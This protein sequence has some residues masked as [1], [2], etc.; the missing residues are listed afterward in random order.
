MQ[1]MIG[2]VMPDSPAAKA[3]IQDGDRIV[4]LDGKK[5]PTWEDVE[6]KEV[7]SA[8]RPMHLTIERDGKR[9]DTTVTP[10]LSERL[11]VGYA[12]WDERGEIQLGARRAGMPGGQG[13]PQEG[14]PA[15][16][17]ERAADAF[18]DQVPRDHREQ[19]RQADARSNSQRDGQKHDV[20]VQ[21]VFAK[22]DGPARWMIGV[23]PEPKLHYRRL[24]AF[25][26]R[27]RS[28]NRCTRTPRAP[29]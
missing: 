17:R 29:C 21:P 24:H 12:G 9:F 27:R 26:C 4:K 15:P 16:R 6:L 19:R 7:T 20:T 22:L 2:H 8:Y 1:A 3:G 23:K 10:I 14:R 25:R 28:A 11:G 5:N 18:A 13:R